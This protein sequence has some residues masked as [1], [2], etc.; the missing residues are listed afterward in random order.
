M[1]RYLY[2]C[3]LTSHADLAADMFRH[4]AAQVRGRVG[5]QH[6][7]DALG[8]ETDACDSLNPLYVIVEGEAGSHLASMRFLPTMGPVIQ[9]DVF[10]HLTGE[11][12]IRSPRI[13]EA[14]RLC[15][16]PGAG[17][18][19]AQHLLL[20]TSELGLGM[21]LSHF[22]GV[23]DAPMIGVYRRVG[24]QPEVLGTKNG[25]SAGI[26]AFTDAVHDRLCALVGI[27]PSQSRH[28]FDVALGDLPLPVRA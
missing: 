10:G 6:T 4:R 13:W 5:W 27:H 24:W 2:A 12:P 15:L 22:V 11:G 7:V 16:A 25:V 18:A 17:P 8:W 21:G 3:D 9:S 20:A 26:W 28:W 19:V 1:I 14:T 23:F